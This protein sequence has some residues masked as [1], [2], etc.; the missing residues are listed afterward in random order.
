MPHTIPIIM[1]IDETMDVGIDTRTGV[2][3]FEYEL[4][5]DFTGTIDKLTIK[6]GPVADVGAGEEGRRGG[7]GRPRQ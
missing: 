3:D 2:D 4:P 1:S 6:I 7:D 5:F